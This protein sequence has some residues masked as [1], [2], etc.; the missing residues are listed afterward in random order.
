M[1]LVQ[2]HDTGFVVPGLSAPRVAELQGRGRR[3]RPDGLLQCTHE[4]LSYPGG[5]EI[6]YPPSE[7]CPGHKQRLR[8]PPRPGVEDRAV[9]VQPDEEIGKRFDYRGQFGCGLPEVLFGQHLLGD[10]PDGEQDAAAL[11]RRPPELDITHLSVP[12]DHAGNHGVPVAP[13]Q[14]LPH[15]L[16]LL[17]VCRVRVGTFE[18]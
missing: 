2:R 15:I 13:E 18:P 7:Q 6:L 9:G 5:E 10:V 1:H 12:A 11:D 8:E 16:H 14:F 17:P 4:C 3:I